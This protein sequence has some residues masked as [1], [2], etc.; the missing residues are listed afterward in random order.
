[1]PNAKSNGRYGGGELAR[2]HKNEEEAAL[3]QFRHS[4]NM[5]ENL[6]ATIP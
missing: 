3:L 1:M 4:S 6:S 2:I 5:R